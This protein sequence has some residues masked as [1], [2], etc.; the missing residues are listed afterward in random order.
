MSRYSIRADFPILESQINGQPL[1]YLDNA[2]TTQKPAVVID[3]MNRYYREDNANVHR[4]AH[5]LAERATNAMESARLSVA[6][7]I[8]A[9]SPDEIIF[10]RGTTESIN[11]VAAGF[12]R[13]LQPGDELLTTVMEHHSNF[14]PWMMA[15]KQAGARLVSVPVSPEGEIDRDDFR[16]RLTDR[17]KLVAFAHVSNAL[18]TV[19]PITELISEIRSRSD[20][21]ILIDGAQAILHL[22]VDVQALDVDF[23]AFSAHKM[24][25]PTGMG[26]LYGKRHRLEALAPWQFG[27]EMI[28][29][30][31]L[32]DVTFNRLPYRFEAGTPNIAGAVGLGAAI[33]Y[34]EQIP[35]T[36]LLAQEA[37]LVDEVVTELTRMPGIR[38][39]G[40][41]AHRLGV[42]SFV[43]PDLH[44]HDIGTLLDQQGVAVRTGHHCTMPLMEYLGVNGTVRASFSLYNERIDLERFLIAMRKVLTFL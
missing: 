32:D 37:E 42:V 3:A 15:A 36:Q 5:T 10:T 26:V 41:P 2:A 11:L 43:V 9:A 7:F 30:V 33:T 19:N 22:P 38:L 24:Y 35:R 40:Q 39:I 17:T 29:R 16:I 34:L 20:A 1:C 6:R 27:G 44:A 25:G 14:V 18:G 13:L 23:Y 12:S 28:E 8:N 4:A 31:T 21:C